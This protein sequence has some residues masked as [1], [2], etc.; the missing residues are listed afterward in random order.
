MRIL[1]L[2]LFSSFLLFGALP[3][4]AGGAMHSLRSASADAGAAFDGSV[5]RGGQIAPQFKAAAAPVS[6][7][8][9]V[10]AQKE[11]SAGKKAWETVKKAAPYAF[12]AGVGLWM[13]V[14]IAGAFGLPAIAFAAVVVLLFAAAK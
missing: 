6:G 8:S 4:K 1:C 3:L 13:G 11:G 9:E 2:F 14:A 5:S 10:L 12:A 7:P